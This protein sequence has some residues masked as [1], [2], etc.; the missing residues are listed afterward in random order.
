M[1]KIKYNYELL[2]SICN[3]EILNNDYNNKKISRDTYIEGKCITENCQNIFC[4]TFRN[5]YE[6]KNLCCDN[7]SKNN[8]KIKAK[9][10]FLINYG[11]ENPMMSEEIKNKIKTTMVNKYGVEHQMYMQETKD[12][13]EQTCLSKYNVK[14]PLKSSFYISIYAIEFINQ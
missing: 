4:R 3:T 12:K 14:H 9:N 8:A 2:Q 6:R 11:V 5:L 10:T 1:S 13:I 7:C